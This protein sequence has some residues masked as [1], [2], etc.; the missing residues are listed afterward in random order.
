MVHQITKGIKI[1]VTSEYRGNFLK[2]H[3]IHY[4]F[5]YTIQIENQS[6]KIVQL[7]SRFWKINDS[8]NHSSTV[9]GEGVVGQKPILTPGE[10][11]TYTSG[12]LLLSGIGSMSGY[13]IL[14]DLESGEEFRVNIPLFKLNSNF[15]M[16]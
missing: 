6:D 5:S 15:V 2:N 16:N 9:E 7:Q 12:C 13:Y 1:S 3:K 8:L 11:H 10:R 4:A 14:T